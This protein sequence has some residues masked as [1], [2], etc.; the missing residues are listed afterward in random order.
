MPD[1]T[2][3][4]ERMKAL[5]LDQRGYPV[6]RF[7]EW[8][9]GAPDFR[10]MSTNH[11]VACVKRKL[12]WIC[13]QPLGVWKVFVIGPMCAVNRISSEPPSHRDCATFAARV[14]PFLSVPHRRRDDRDLP[15]DAKSPAGIMI[16]HNPGATLL[17][18]TN[19]YTVRKEGGGVLFGIGEPHQVEWWARG[20]H[21]S[22]DEVV[23]SFDKGLPHLREQAHSAEEL[24]MIDRQLEKAMKLV[25]A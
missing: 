19:S 2:G 20:R 9:D 22:R 21:A 5:P 24:V 10:V 13:G 16:A 15:E 12:C 17:W 6:P 14:C 8:I 1:L 4:P 25:P 18:I 7:V 11:M 3:L 23:A